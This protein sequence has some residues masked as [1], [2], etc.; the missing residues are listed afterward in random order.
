MPLKYAFY[1]QYFLLS[2]RSNVSFSNK[3]AM[4]IPIRCALSTYA[5]PIPFSLYQFYYR[6]DDVLHIRLELGDKVK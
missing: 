5:G 6:H 3:S 4:R 2:R 1:I